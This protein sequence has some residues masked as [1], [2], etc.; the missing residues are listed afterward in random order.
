MTGKNLPQ[1]LCNC[2]LLVKGEKSRR[3]NAVKAFLKLQE[4]PL[5]ELMLKKLSGSFK[6]IY[7]VTTAGEKF[8]CYQNEKVKVLTDQI[9]CGPMGGI[10]LGLKESNAA[11]NFVLAVDQVF[12]PEQLLAWMMREKKDYQVLVPEVNGKLQ[13]LCAIYHHSVRETMERKIRERKYKLS[14]L[15][16]EVK[17]RYLKQGLEKFGCPEILFF[18]INTA[19]DREKAQQFIRRDHR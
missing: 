6:Q 11:Y 4:Q 14:S 18:N 19:A 3:L 15:L 16:G 13:V 7:L 5:I 2:L 10:F 12:I 1:D 17:T 9:K 8:A